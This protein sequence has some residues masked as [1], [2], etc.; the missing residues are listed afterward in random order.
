MAQLW[1][2]AL[3]S[4][5]IYVLETF[6]FSVIVY[7]FTFIEHIRQVLLEKGCLERY[8]VFQTLSKISLFDTY[9]MLIWL[10][11]VLPWKQLCSKVL[12]VLLPCFLALSIAVEKSD[13]ILSFV[14][15]SLSLSHHLQ[16]LLVLSILEFYGALPWCWYTLIRCTQR[17]LSD[18][19]SISFSSEKLS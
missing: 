17:D 13:A 14:P 16:D 2:W 12:K 11:K 1:S 18:W 4:P 10:N 6:S 3:P 5:M 9:T 7:C 15:T 19:K 8:I